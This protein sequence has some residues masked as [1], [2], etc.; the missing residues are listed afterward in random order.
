MVNTSAKSREYGPRQEG[1]SSIAAQII[2]DHANAGAY[3][4]NIDPATDDRPYFSQFLTLRGL[5]RLKNDYG[6]GMVPFFELG[7]LILIVTALLISFLACILI[8]LPL[9]KSRPSRPL[10]TLLYFAGLG[11][12]FLFLEIAFIQYAL[13]YL[14]APMYA[15]AIVIGGVLFFSGLGSLTSGWMSQAYRIVPAMIAALILLYAMG[16]ARLLQLASAQPMAARIA[17]LL[18]AIAP[19]AF[20]MGMPFP[21][22]LSRLPREDVPWAWGVNGCLSVMS[23]PAASIIAVELGFSRVMLFAALAYVVAWLGLICKRYA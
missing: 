12:G 17:V 7:Y 18:I 19:I 21:L 22:G 10:P 3:D 2:S 20:C 15:A 23:A 1:W 11:A 5:A 9:M 6:S 8:L 16:F 4:F 14:G 13:A